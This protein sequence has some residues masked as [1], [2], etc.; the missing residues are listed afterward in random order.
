MK[1]IYVAGPL[2]TGDNMANVRRAVDVSNELASAGFAVFC[3]H[4]TFF[5]EILHHHPYEFWMKQDFAWLRKCDA[6]VVLPGKSPG[7]E[8]EV[9]E[10]RVMGLSIYEWNG[11]STIQD[12]MADEGL[13][14]RLAI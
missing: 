4:L 13:Q 9:Q 12:L 7:A 2:T 6:V 3:P 5:W 10:A 8:R 14:E 1:H 11:K